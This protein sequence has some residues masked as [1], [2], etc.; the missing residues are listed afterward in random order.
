MSKEFGLTKMFKQQA[1][2]RLGNG[3]VDVLEIGRKAEAFVTHIT[4]EL[5]E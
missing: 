4:Q 2:D 3:P 5:N 1:P